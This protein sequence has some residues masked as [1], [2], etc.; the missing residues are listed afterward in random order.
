VTPLTKDVRLVAL[1]SQ[2][3]GVGTFATDEYSI[4]EGA[5]ALTAFYTRSAWPLN[6]G[7]DVV[8]VQGW[9]STDGGA[10]WLPLLSLATK[11]GEYINP[12]TGS[13]A[14]SEQSMPVPPG[15]LV[16]F[17]IEVLAALTTAVELLAQ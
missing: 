17:D 3:V 6:N 4:P 1:A 9:V 7:D 5:S 12:R 16:Q 2:A 8:R 10:S 15:S 11:G 14:Q 13:G